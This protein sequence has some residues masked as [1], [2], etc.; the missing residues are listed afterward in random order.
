MSGTLI[1]ISGWGTDESMW[2]PVI[3]SMHGK[4]TDMCI[5]WWGCLDETDNSLLKTLEGLNNSVTLVGWSL[6]SM[7]ALSGAVEF[8]EKVANL[9]LV[10]SMARMTGIENYRGADSKLLKAMRVKFK[11]DPESVLHDFAEICFAPASREKELAWFHDMSQNIDRTNLLHGLHYLEK[12]DLRDKLKGLEMPTL[13]L[14]GNR[15]RVVPFS[16]GQYLADAITQGY[17]V[18]FQESGHALPLVRPEQVAGAI[19]EFF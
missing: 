2:Q 3:R 7:I 6:G 9:V 15:D 18:E 13:I 19:E 16:C 5:P 11:R 17:L 1:F 14:H 10:S 8:P 4:V 12:T